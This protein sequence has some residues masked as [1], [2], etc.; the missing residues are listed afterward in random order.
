MSKQKRCIAFTGKKGLDPT[1]PPMSSD[2]PHPPVSHEP[3]IQELHDKL[4]SQGHKPFYVPLGVNL[5]E[6]D[7]HN[8]ACIRCDTCDGFPCLVDAKSDTDI[9]GI[10][11]SLK[12]ENITLLTNTRVMKLHTSEDGNEISEVEALCKGEHLRFNDTV[13]LSCGS[14]NSAALLLQSANEKHPNG[15]A[16]SSDQV[17]RNFMKH[18]NGAMLG[19]SLKKNS[20]VFQKTMAIN[21]Y[22]WG[23]K[24][25]NYPMG[26]V[27]LLGKANKEMLRGDAPP[28]TPSFVLNWMAKHSDFAST[29]QGKPSQVSQRIQALLCLS[30]SFRLTPSGT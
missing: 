5:N 27:Q 30:F 9:N 26:H 14:T 8:S 15:L 11:P 19:I 21:D 1:E 13:I 4:S 16:N 10:R 25:Y 6:K 22:Y 20:T 7:R 12:N 18:V 29:R 23:E 28:F 3:C 24:G 17:G 2:Y